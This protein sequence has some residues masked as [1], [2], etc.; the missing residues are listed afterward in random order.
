MTSAVIL[1]VSVDILSKENFGTAR[2]LFKTF[3][4]KPNARVQVGEPFSLDKIENLE[5]IKELTDKRKSGAHLTHEEISEFSKITKELREKSEVLIKK[6][7]EI[8]PE[9]KRGDISLE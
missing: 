6:L 2:N 3:L 5:R 1:P 7:A 4:K 8:T 9:E